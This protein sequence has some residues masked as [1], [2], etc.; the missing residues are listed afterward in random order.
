MSIHFGQVPSAAFKNGLNIVDADPYL[1]P[2]AMGSVIFLAVFIDS[3]RQI[4][5]RKMSRRRLQRAF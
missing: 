5:L 4:Q 2:L 1:Y 3:L